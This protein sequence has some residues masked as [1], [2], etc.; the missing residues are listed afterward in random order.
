MKLI[1]M[2]IATIRLHR[3]PAHRCK[4]HIRDGGENDGC[5][6]TEWAIF[7]RIGSV[8]MR[9]ERDGRHDGCIDRAR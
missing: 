3:R 6:T 8:G 1:Q 2:I 5:A 9:A 7:E 4:L